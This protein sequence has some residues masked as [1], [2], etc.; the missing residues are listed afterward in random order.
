M[1]KIGRKSP[2]QPG[3]VPVDHLPI[4]VRAYVTLAPKKKKKG[5]N[6]PDTTQQKFTSPTDWVLIFDCETRTTPDQALRF[7][8]Y[9]LRN[10][11][12]FVERGVF[13]DETAFDPDELVTLRRFMEREEP[14]LDGERV[15]LRTRDE[16]VDQVFYGS[17]YKLGAQIVGFNLPFDISRLALGFR[18][19]RRDMKSGFSFTLVDDEKYNPVSVRHLSQRAS[20]M[21]F[22]GIKKNKRWIEDDDDDDEDLDFE[23]SLRTD[24]GFFVDVK[25]FAAALMLSN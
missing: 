12:R 23:S 25:T 8:A 13:F 9:Q 20:W 11:S 2:P 5:S 15:C 10:G 19:S 6:K 17:G 16:F 1:P 21:R 7:G 18:P 14:S 22:V 4:S 24:R 3:D